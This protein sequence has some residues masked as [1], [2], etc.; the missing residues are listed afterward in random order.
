MFCS[1]VPNPAWPMAIWIMDTDIFQ[2]NKNINL[3]P[4]ICLFI[5]RI[6][7]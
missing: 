6:D 7:L 5:A 2:L 3:P 1:Q 4:L